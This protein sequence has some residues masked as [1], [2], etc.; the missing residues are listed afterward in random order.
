MPADLI[1][2][3]AA[4]ASPANFVSF[5]FAQYA[6]DLEPLYTDYIDRRPRT[7]D[8]VLELFTWKNGGSLSALK[9]QSVIRNYVPTMNAAPPT[10]ARVFLTETKGGATWSIFWLHCLNHEFPIYD[11]HVHRAMTFIESGERE[12]LAAHP[13]PEK[14][15]LY[16][17]RYL[18]FCKRFNGLDG[19]KVDRALWVFGKLLKAA[20]KF[21]GLHD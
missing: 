16:L 18:P 6:H 12:E 4:A 15:E 7:Q 8:S 11:Q 17:S 2:Y 1:V 21:P 3:R 13:D 9:K 5:W 20:Q 14:I 19:R 10:D